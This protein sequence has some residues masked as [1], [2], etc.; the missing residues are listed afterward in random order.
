[1]TTAT[2]GATTAGAVGTAHTRVEG[3]DKVTGAA[4]YAGEIPFADLAHGWLVLSTVARGRI[5]TTTTLS[6]T[7]SGGVMFFTC[8]SRIRTSK[9]CWRTQLARLAKGRLGKIP[10]FSAARRLSGCWSAASWYLMNR[11]RKAPTPLGA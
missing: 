3:R 2:T 4:R 9:P 7:P 10:S 5:R 6:R 11:T 8:K 1:M